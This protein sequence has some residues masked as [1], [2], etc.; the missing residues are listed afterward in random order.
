M[1]ISAS[2]HL[3]ASASLCLC[4]SASLHLCVSV[5]L[6]LCVSS[7]TDVCQ[8]PQPNGRISNTSPKRTYCQ[9]PPVEHLFNIS[10]KNFK[11]LKPLLHASLSSGGCTHKMR[12]SVP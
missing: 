3:C 1:G 6:G 10:S 4:V 7:K 12:F 11:C 9:I 5:S 8:I 2:L